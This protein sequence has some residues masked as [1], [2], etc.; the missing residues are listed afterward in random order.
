MAVKSFHDTMILKKVPYYFL[1]F[2]GCALHAQQDYKGIM[3]DAIT[4]KPIPYVNIGIVNRGIGTV[5]DEEGLFHL[6]L[7]KEA[8]TQFDSLQFSSLGYKTINSAIPDLEYVYNEYP[9]IAMQPAT[10]ILDEIIVSNQGILKEVGTKEVGHTNHGREIFGYWKGQVALGGEMGTKINVRKGIRL[11]KDLTFTIIKNPSD[12]LLIRVNIYDAHTRVPEVKL[13][14]EN[15]IFS[16]TQSSGIVNI[17]LEPFKIYVTNDFT[18]SLELLKFYG[19]EIGLVLL[20]SEDLGVSYKRYASHD[21]WKR[22]GPYTLAFVLN[23][24]LFKPEDDFDE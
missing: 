18:V 2:I 10:V 4:K 9:V 19:D 1:I 16:I 17:D 22:I 20:G 5:S 12:S 8:Y 14:K 6:P 3:V 7:N 21:K 11:L 15:I 23:T 13:T 24:G